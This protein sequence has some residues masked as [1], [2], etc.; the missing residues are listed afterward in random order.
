MMGL[1]QY[2]LE[3]PV[4]KGTSG[5]LALSQKEAEFE[6]PR[7]PVCIRCGRCVEACPM[8]LVPTYLAAMAHREKMED[9]ERLNVYDCFECGCCAYVCP[10]RN[11]LVQLIKAGK[12]EL[13]RRKALAERRAQEAANRGS[14]KEGGDGVG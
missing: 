11:P 8:S 10:T 14:G 1:A 3:V 6:I 12:A 2:T 9:L 4:I 13:S 5:I 7:E